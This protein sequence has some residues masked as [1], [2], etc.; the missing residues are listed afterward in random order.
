[1]RPLI[2]TGIV[3]EVLLTVFLSVGC[4]KNKSEAVIESQPVTISPV[5]GH[6]DPD[7]S[8]ISIDMD[9]ESIQFHEKTMV[10]PQL[11]NQFDVFTRTLGPGY[12]FGTIQSGTYAGAEFVLAEIESDEPCKGPACGNWYARFILIGK[13]LI[14]LPKN[15]NIHESSSGIGI[16]ASTFSAQGYTLKVAEEFS[17]EQFTRFARFPYS[18]GAFSGETT[19]FPM[20]DKRSLKKAFN[21]PPYGDFYFDG[22]SFY[23]D[24]PDG[25]CWVF[26]FIPDITIDRV[27]WNSAPKFINKSGYSWAENERYGEPYNPHDP[28]I[29]FSDI[30]VERD[31][32]QIGSTHRGDP[33][34]SLKDQNHR[35]LKDLYSEYLKGIQFETEYRMKTSTAVPYSDFVESVPI[36]F[37]KDPFDRFTRFSSNDF[38]PTYWAEPIIY[39]YSP[40]RQKVK[41]TVNSKEEISQS[42]PPYGKGWTV[43]T[44]PDGSITNLLGKK[45]PYLFWE[46]FGPIWPMREEGYVVLREKV[47]ELFDSVL[48]QLGLNGKEIGDFKSAWLP[49]FMD[50][51]HYFITFIDPETI[52]H[53]APL[54]IDPNPDTTIRILMDFQPL[55]QDKSVP[56]PK[57]RSPPIRKGFTVVEWGGIWRAKRHE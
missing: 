8:R 18:G 49:R 31:L 54:E 43:F 7:I 28:Y 33:I 11:I 36:F 52:N 40:T 23:A 20:P 26:G 6:Q 35:L 34:Y 50:A 15:S 9:N 55:G 21:H 1:M 47:G 32:I 24:S 42:D 14:F 39:L 57:F 29:S 30:V 13:D 3:L 46:G 41:V 53:L 38:L 22:V 17:L 45:Y 44:E 51:S 10:F 4:K 16:W 27:V 19:K 25:R 48:P 37:W 5:L 56:P 12:S 2:Q